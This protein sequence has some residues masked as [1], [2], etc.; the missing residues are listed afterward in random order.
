MSEFLRAS[1][2][3]HPASQPADAVKLCYQS[4]FAGGHMIADAEKSLA[5]LKEELFALPDRDEPLFEPIGGGYARLNLAGARRLGL[6]PETMN[7]L[8]VRAANRCRGTMRDFSERLS[9]LRALCQAGG[10]PFTPQALEAYLTDYKLR[11]SPAVHHSDAY[12]EA[13]APAYRVVLED[14]LKY[15][16]ALTRIDARLSCGQETVVAI[17]GRCGSG[18]TTLSALLCEL[19]GAPAVHMDDFFLPPERK[20]PERLAQPGGNVDRERFSREVLP[21]LLS[22][23][24]FAYLP[25]NCHAGALSQDAVQVP[26]ARVRVVEG[27]YCLHPEIARSY[28][29][30]LFLTV[31]SQT[32]RRRIL[33]R[34]GAEMLARFELEWIPLEERYFEAF[35]IEKACDAVIC[36]D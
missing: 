18:K 23:E 27:V 10:C 21:G 14:D 34:S 6:L 29:V 16:P 12:R 8:F 3:A 20:T 13:Y 30:K 1:L 4:A 25:Y 33:A 24:A 17:D 9:A 11:G 5:F 36:T 28:H 31:S 32:Q 7:A 19:Y 15:L 35:S 26:A 2:R 22:G